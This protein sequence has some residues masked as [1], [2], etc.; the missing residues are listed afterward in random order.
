MENYAVTVG[1]AMGRKRMYCSKIL[2]LSPSKFI[3]EVPPK[4]D[5]QSRNNDFLVDEQMFI[6]AEEGK[7]LRLLN[8]DPIADELCWFCVYGVS[9]FLLPRGDLPICLLGKEH[10]PVKFCRDF[11]PGL[12]FGEDLKQ[13]LKRRRLAE[14]LFAK[15]K[16][17]YC[18]YCEHYKEK[19][20]T[21]TS[22]LGEI[23][24]ETKRYCN[25][26][27]KKPTYHWKNPCINFKLTSNPQKRAELEKQKR[28]IQE[29]LNK[30]KLIENQ[31]DDII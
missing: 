1:E 18:Y 27:K 16:L 22:P 7:S 5:A 29:Y 30:L 17:E 20:V 28:K 2:W 4:H 12:A 31:N 13:D 9:P 24:I 10:S 25:K 14:K 11:S 19:I 8:G 3:F 6:I 15:I 21:R 23:Y 26:I